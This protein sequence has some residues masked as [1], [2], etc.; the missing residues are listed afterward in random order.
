MPVGACRRLLSSLRAYR[1][2]SVPIGACRCLSAAAVGAYRWPWLSSSCPCE[3]APLLAKLK[4]SLFTEMETA[5]PPTS[6][7]IKSQCVY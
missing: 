6:Q 2:L 4:C 7:K 3:S 5:Q 1:C